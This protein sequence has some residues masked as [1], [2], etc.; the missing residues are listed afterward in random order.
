MRK[1]SAAELLKLM[2]SGATIEKEDVEPMVVEG[3]ATLIEQMREIAETQQQMNQAQCDVMAT[4]VT[5]LT[6][7][8]VNFKGGTVDL[9][10]LEKLIEQLKTPP[11]VEKPNYRFNVQRNTRGFITGMTVAPDTPTLN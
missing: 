1:L 9:K 2:S 4:A 3:L 10:P 5:N 6:K 8:L 11:V 7:A